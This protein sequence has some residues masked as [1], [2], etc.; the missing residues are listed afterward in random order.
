MNEIPIGS[1][2]ELPFVTLEVCESRGCSACWFRDLCDEEPT[3]AYKLV[4]TCLSDERSDKK[5]VCFKVVERK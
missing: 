5:D 2:I 1:K 4:G 3:F